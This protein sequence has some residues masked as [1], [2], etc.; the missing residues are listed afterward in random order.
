MPRLPPELVRSVETL[1]DLTPDQVDEA[2]RLAHES[3]GQAAS[4]L[5]QLV[6]KCHLGWAADFIDHFLLDSDEVDVRTWGIHD[7]LYV[8]G[9]EWDQLVTEPLATCLTLLE[10][11]EGESFVRVPP[12]NS[13]LRYDHF[14]GA[15]GVIVRGKPYWCDLSADRIRGLMSPRDLE[16]ITN[17]EIAV[18]R[19]IASRVAWR[20]DAGKRPLPATVGEVAAVLELKA[21]MSRDGEIAVAGLICEQ[22]MTGREEMAPG[23]RGPDEWYA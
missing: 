4:Y 11:I 10:K 20:L 16:P 22:G 8:P 14:C 3:K 13:N 5:Q 7:S 19:W 2:R 9:L 23:F 12:R 21:P 18:R 1:N 6:V 17:V 15:P